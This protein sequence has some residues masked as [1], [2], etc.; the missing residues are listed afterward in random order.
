[1]AGRLR[2]AVCRLSIEWNEVGLGTLVQLK[3]A[4]F[5]ISMFC[6]DTAPDQMPSQLI[7]FRNC[8]GDIKGEFDL[9]RGFPGGS[10]VKN[11]PA[12]TGDSENEGS[13]PGLGRFPGGG[14][15]NLLLYSCLENPTDRGAW[16][17]TVHEVTE[18]QTRFSNST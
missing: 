11:L 7:N 18:S 9:Y 3:R 4:S 16:R 12:N 8:E 17:A 15:G 5:P 1:M 2:D 10:V 13:I 14:N 6:A